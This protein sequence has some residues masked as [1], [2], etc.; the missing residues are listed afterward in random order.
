[1]TET[2]SPTPPDEGAIR[3]QIE[4]LVH[5]GLGAALG[6]EGRAEV[7]ERLLAEHRADTAREV[8]ALMRRLSER[9]GDE[10]RRQ[11]VAAPEP[12]RQY[13]RFNLNMRVQHV[14]LFASCI[15]LILTGLPLKFHDTAVAAFLFG[16]MGGVE[17]SSLIHRIGAAF[18]IGVGLFHL[19]YTFFTRTGW[20]DFVNL[21]PTPKD[22]RDLVL[23]LRYFLGRTNEQPRFGRFSYVEKFDYW[24]VYWGMVIMCGSGWLLWFENQTLRV[25][26]KYMIDIAKEAH[27]DEALLATLA[28]I[29]WHFYNVHLN[30]RKFPMN[31]VWITGRLSEE[32]MQH[33]H[34]LELEEI[35]LREAE[36]EGAR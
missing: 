15:V 22:G 11:P 24:A 23:M 27:S 7:V 9:L 14:V 13:V 6:R 17:N 31:R 21:I 25:L 30:P 36:G 5:Q 4:A 10:L 32:E 33:E 34:P 3:R 28:I 2:A 18:L 26:P 20:R 1:M 19:G 35:R 16:L 8:E 29:V 12:A